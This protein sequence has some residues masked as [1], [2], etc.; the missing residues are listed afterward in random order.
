MQP[1]AAHLSSL[2]PDY[3]SLYELDLGTYLT[4][5]QS[6]PCRC[7]LSMLLSVLSALVLVAPVARRHPTGGVRPSRCRPW[8]APTLS[9][10]SAC[11]MLCCKGLAAHVN[12]RMSLAHLFRLYSSSSTDLRRSGGPLPSWSRMTL[13]LGRAI[14]LPPVFAEPNRMPLARLLEL[15]VLSAHSELTPQRYHTKI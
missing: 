7:Y 10:C 8:T 5:A 14:P 12:G 13:S 4:V 15:V 1:S 6:Q 11:W 9:S 2:A 3:I